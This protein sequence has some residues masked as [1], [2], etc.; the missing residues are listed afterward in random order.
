MAKLSDTQLMI[1]SAAA[2]RE[3]GA[4][5]LPDKLKGGAARK[6]VDSLIARKLVTEVARAGE[7]PVWR[8]D[9]DERKFAL[10]ITAEGLAEIGVEPEVSE[11]A[12]MDSSP[13][14]APAPAPSETPR[15][16]HQGSKQAQLIEML[17]RL[18]GATIEQIV[19]ATG[20]QKHTV[21]SV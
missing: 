12:E 3:D 6:V 4:I 7:M 2:Q 11:T 21:T 17:H 5:V 16:T 18:E 8:T 9:E 20:W 10:R 14:A 1:L 13:I 15:P 19:A